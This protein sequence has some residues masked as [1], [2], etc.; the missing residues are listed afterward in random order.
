MPAEANDTRPLRQRVT[1]P[2]ANLAEHPRE[3][4]FEAVAGERTDLGYWEWVEERIQQTADC[5]FFDIARAL[6]EGWLLC[7]SGSRGLQ[8]EK[9]DDSDVF[10]DDVAAQEFVHKKAIDGSDY[11]QRALEIVKEARA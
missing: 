3:E 1:H 11:H 6:A 5:D 8:V 4:W 2:H 10:S 7:D 9:D